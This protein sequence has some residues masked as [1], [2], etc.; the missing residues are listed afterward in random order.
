VCKRFLQ[1]AC[2][3]EV[4]LLS[5]RVAPE[6]MPACK[7]FLEGL[8]TKLQCPYLHVKVT[9]NFSSFISFFSSFYFV[10]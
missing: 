5:H 10:D 9:E 1:G 6:K 3:K 2:Q 4:C 7:Y 8:C